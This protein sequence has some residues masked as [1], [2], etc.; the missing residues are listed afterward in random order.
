MLSHEFEDF[1]LPCWIPKGSKMYVMSTPDQETL[2]AGFLPGQCISKCPKV[3]K[4]KLTKQ[5]ICCLFEHDSNSQ[6]YSLQS[7][8]IMIPRRKGY[9]WIQQAIW[10]NWICAPCLWHNGINHSKTKKTKTSEIPVVLGGR[11]DRTVFFISIFTW[12]TDGF[13]PS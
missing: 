7:W 9:T 2:A 10:R 1:P 11:H 12:W 5:W 6:S 4:P 8:S 3:S 13:P